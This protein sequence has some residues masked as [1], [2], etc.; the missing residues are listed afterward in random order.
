MWNVPVVVHFVH[1]RR[2]KFRRQCGRRIA[3]GRTRRRVMKQRTVVTGK[4]HRSLV[5]SWSAAFA[6]RTGRP[7]IRPSVRHGRSP[8][9]V[10]LRS[11]KSPEAMCLGGDGIQPG[12]D[13]ALVNRRGQAK[14]PD[15]ACRKTLYYRFHH[16]IVLLDLKMPPEPPE[17]PS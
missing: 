16:A 6:Q 3:R 11:G 2:G 4:Q 13:H 7:D 17:N 10:A 15:R 9:H 1:S 12:S 8:P 5:R 14:T